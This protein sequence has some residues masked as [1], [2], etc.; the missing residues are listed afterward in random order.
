M[1]IAPWPFRAF[2]DYFRN[3]NFVSS[4]TKVSPENM[5][6]WLA[7]TNNH[8]SVAIQSTFGKLSKFE[9]KNLDFATIGQIEYCDVD[10]KV[11]YSRNDRELLYLK[12]DC[13]EFESEVRL[14]IQ[15]NNPFDDAGKKL[16]TFEVEIPPG[17]IEKVIAHPKMDNQTFELLE[18]LVHQADQNIKVVRPK[19]SARPSD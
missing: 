9:T 4:W 14:S 16:K 6:M 2:E 7:Y 13:F 17:T 19:I 12:R 3:I 15:V 8:S 5:T 1:G 10:N 18:S 11:H